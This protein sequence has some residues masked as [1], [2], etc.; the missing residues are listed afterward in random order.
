MNNQVSQIS[1][2]IIGADLIR[3]LAIIFVIAGHY[4]SINTTFYTDEF[5]GIDMIIK[6]AALPILFTGVPL[7]L[8][9]TGFLNTKKTLSI[10]HYKGIRR[11]IESYLFFSILTIFF[12][13]FY[14]NEEMPIYKWILRILDFTV[15]PYAWYIEMYIGLFLLIPFLNI[16]YRNLDTQKKKQLL[17]LTCFCLSSL[18]ALLNR[19]GLKIIPDFWNAIYPITYYF[20]GS[21]ICE[22]RPQIKSQWK[23]WLLILC[24]ILID[25]IA[26]TLFN[27][28]VYISAARTIASPLCLI[29]AS[30]LFIMYYSFNVE[31]VAFKNIITKTSLLSLDIYLC[32][33][34]FDKLVY[35]F[36]VDQYMLIIVPIVFCLS[37]VTATFK[38]L[39]FKLN[40]V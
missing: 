9:L 20:I 22:Y 36:F 28:G 25:P 34:I 32:S 19:H 8:I 38:D 29:I 17:L 27:Q 23:A 1:Q 4:I 12:R 33:Y 18:P 14:L 6:S 30:C 3:S 35:P 26:N 13:V 15:I 39:L 7:F 40:K 10:Q 31:Y 37:F 2:R 21:Y 24:L 5:S 16:M 11:I